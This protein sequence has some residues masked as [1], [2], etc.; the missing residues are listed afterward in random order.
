MIEQVTQFF[1]EVNNEAS[2]QEKVKEVKDIDSLIKI[3]QK[4]GGYNFTQKDL[5][6]GINNL[7]KI[8]VYNNAKKRCEATFFFAESKFE[9]K[10]VPEGIGGL[11]YLNSKIINLFKQQEQPK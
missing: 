9:F 10:K 4:E 1:E 11:D 6:I 2:W 7:L 3:A 8:K 5:K